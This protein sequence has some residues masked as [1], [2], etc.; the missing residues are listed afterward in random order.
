MRVGDLLHAEMA[1]AHAP[2]YD[3]F[4]HLYR[5]RTAEGVR[6]GRRISSDRL[7]ECRDMRAVLAQELRDRAASEGIDGWICPSTREVAPVGYQETG[8]SALTGFWSYAG[9]P[10]ISVPV[11]DGANGMPL[12]V[13]LVTTAGRDELLLGWA[14]HAESALNG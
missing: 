11:S 2:W 6:I 9:F 7:R 13:Q 14:A 10:A 3:R 8:D 1:I 12:G 5:P 4:E